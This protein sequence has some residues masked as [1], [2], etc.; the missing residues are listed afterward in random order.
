[1]YQDH[2]PNV[3]GKLLLCFYEPSLLLSVLDPL[4]QA[5]RPD[6]IHDRNLQQPKKIWRNFLD[7]LS[8]LCDSESGSDTMTSV[9]TVLWSM[10]GLR[11]KRLL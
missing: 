2:G 6:F 4:R 5:H 9:A 10:R 7:Q 11:R 3:N 8:F 1:M